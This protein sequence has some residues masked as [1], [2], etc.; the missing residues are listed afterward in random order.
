MG[1]LDAWGW[2]WSTTGRASE[3]HLVVE[4]AV[5]AGL[6]KKSPSSNALRQHMRVD[7]GWSG[8]V[9]NRR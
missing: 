9:R 7:K 8:R 6:G 4:H 1:Q 3:G 2:I 5:L